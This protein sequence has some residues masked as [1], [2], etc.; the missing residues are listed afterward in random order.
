MRRL[1]LPVAFGVLAI[2]LLTAVFLTNQ[3]VA[4]ETDAPPGEARV[5]VVHASP[6]APNVDVWI[7]GALALTNVPFAQISNYAVLSASSHL[8]QVEPAG[9]GGAGPF[10]ISATVALAADT[11][12][13]IAA[14]GAVA[15]IE[16]LVLEDDNAIPAA[17][18]AHVRFVH[19]S[20][21]APA[22]DI[23]LSDGTVLF[24][25]YEFKEFS[26]YLPVDAGTYDLQV[27]LA[28]TST[29][30]L[31]LPDIALADQ[32]V[33]TVFAMGFATPGSTPGLQ[34][35]V[36]EDAGLANI[37][38]AHLS[39]DA[40]NVDI[41][42]NGSVAIPDVA[43][44]EITEY[45]SLPSDAYFIEVVPAGFATPVVISAT[46]DLMP[47]Q[48][49]TV[50]AVGELAAIEPLVLQDD[51]TI[52]GK[53]L[54]HIRFVHA[55][56]DAPAVDITLPD[57]TVLFGDYEFKESSPYLPVPAGTYDLEVRLAG[58]DTVVLPLDGLQFAQ[59]TV[60]TAFATGFAGGG[61]PALN[62][63][64][65]E[66]AGTAWVK[67][68]HLSPDAPNVDVW[69]DGQ[70][71]FTDIAFEEL[72]AY[73]PLSAGSYLVQVEP[74][75]SGGAGPFVIS[76][77]LDLESGTDYT[78]AA[79]GELSAIEPL[80]LVDDNSVPAVGFAHVRF[81]HASPDAPAVDI[82]LTD[83]TVLFGDYEFKEASPYLPV[84][85]GAY[86]LEVRLAG[87]DTVVLPL[88]GVPFD[89]QD[90]YTVFATGFAAGGPP[91]L[92]ALLAKY[93]DTHVSYFPVIFR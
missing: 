56:P 31:E 79:V 66:D 69:V 50:A 54:S 25:D 89:N 88:A 70:V 49:Y 45:V 81:V 91:A 7:D 86:D 21:D 65:S 53:N 55:S 11:D 5:R 73:A 84:N 72:T 83:G 87:T 57:G 71:A 74:A 80:V 13:T 23:T 76:A 43:F 37:R 17:N 8:I 34:A 15:A 14:V 20:P 48:D 58:T 82:T 68:A 19:A 18:K 29:V 35:V 38:V 77:T 33:Y 60:Y 64:V 92:N 63:I 4:A 42:V 27:R 39:P 2:A 46:L 26:P 1:F 30:V 44:E 75:G 9:S 51:N 67:V 36:G 41:R 24:G 62:A 85:W 22:V 47:N 3:N 93:V 28:G 16:P 6:D 10:V 78:V 32:T 61:S 52:P 12:Y 40:P 90:V 59:R